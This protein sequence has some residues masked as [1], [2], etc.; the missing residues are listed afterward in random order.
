MGGPILALHAQEQTPSAPHRLRR[1]RNTPQDP[2]PGATPQPRKNET[3]SEDDGD[4]VRVD[5]DLTNIL[6]TAIDK[7]QRFIT[8]LRRED[9]R[10]TENNVPQEISIF[11]REAELPL[12]LAILIDTSRSQERSLP[13]EKEAAR[14]FVDSVIRPEKDQAAVISFTGEAR[15]EQE[16]TNNVSTLKTAIS[17]VKVELPLNNPECK[18]SEAADPIEL[19]RHCSTG[20]WDALWVTAN[21]VLSHTPERTRRAIILLSDGDDTSSETTREEAIDRAVKAN[22]VIY[23]IGIGDPDSYR[24]DKGALRKVSERTGGRAFFPPDKPSLLAAFAQIQQELRSQYLIGYSTTNKK[25][26]GAFRQVRI[27]ITNPELRKQKLRLLYRQGYYAKA[28]MKDESGGT[29]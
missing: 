25:R 10:I 21:E 1:T 17:R 13:D 14:T 9:L 18:P 12:S 4:V 27:E 3:E 2:S 22:V 7:N 26:D 23:A 28:R 16:L 24:I 11:E 19:K 6:L 5:T 20:I 29:K 8:T 15:L